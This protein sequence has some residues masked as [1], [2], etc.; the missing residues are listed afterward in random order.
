MISYNKQVN[1]K[2]QYCPSPSYLHS[3]FINLNQL[4]GELDYNLQK[5]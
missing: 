5:W 4:I 1:H 3:L 2:I